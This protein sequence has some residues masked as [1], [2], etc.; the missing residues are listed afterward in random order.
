MTLALIQK[1]KSG[2]IKAYTVLMDS[3]YGRAK[4]EGEINQGTFSI[5]AFTWAQTK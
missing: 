4:Q 3:A 1:A 2:D 5:P